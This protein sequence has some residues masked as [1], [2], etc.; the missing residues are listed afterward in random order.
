MK[1]DNAVIMAAGTSSRFA[2]LSHEK[3]KAM[4]NVKGEILIEREIRQL[5]DAGVPKIYIVTGYKAE[6]FDYLRDKFGVTLIH[7]PDYLS[8]NNQA[9][10]WAAKDVLRNS[11]VCSADNFFSKNP[12]EREVEDSYYAAVY[13]Q[14]HTEEWCMEEDAQGYIRSVSIGG[15][16]AWYMLGH[17]FWS[18]EFSRKF[19]EILEAEYHL[20]QTADKLWEKIFMEHLDV[21]KMK[22][23]KYDSDTIFEFDT[24]DELRAFDE[25]YRSDTRSL[26]IKKVAAELGVP[27]SKIIQIRSYKQKNNAAAG[28]TFQC[29][30]QQYQYSY[31]SG[32]LERYQNQRGENG[33]G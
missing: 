11:Y 1:V 3:H 19:L 30:S 14:G 10:I 29:D 33:N 9:S 31:S 26:L 23:R 5:M 12:F 13:A 18:E 24:L 25:T 15:E 8:R 4:I 16:N 2:P 7:N 27:E 28:F 32:I 6:Q 22:I 20:P 17:T 21:L